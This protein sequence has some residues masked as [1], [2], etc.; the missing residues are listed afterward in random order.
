MSFTVVLYATE[1]HRS[2]MEMSKTQ[3][4]AWGADSIMCY[5]P[6]DLSPAFRRRNRDTLSCPK[7][8]GCWVW[9]PWI[10]MDAMKRSSTDYVMY[11]DVSCKMNSN[12]R[13][14]QIVM[15][16]KDIGISE[17]TYFDHGT[18]TKRTH[19][20]VKYTKK[21][22]FTRFGVEQD[23]A[24]PAHVTTWMCFRRV[25]SVATAFV[26]KWLSFAQEKS[27]I[28]DTLSDDEHPLLVAHR[29]DQ[30]IASVLFNMSHK[31]QGAIDM[32]FVCKH[33]YFDS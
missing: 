7:G 12:K 22:V 16:D 2:L 25:S 32:D 33:H 23:V 15:N 30:S 10:I 21:A 19:P 13:G 9:K 11:I 20:E 24:L 8:A 3:F 1:S 18:K 28:D 4:E 26:S 27:L 17:A 5:G 29:H 31:T 14:M 6:K